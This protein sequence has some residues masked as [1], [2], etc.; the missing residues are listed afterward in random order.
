[1]LTFGFTQDMYTGLLDESLYLFDQST[2]MSV[3]LDFSLFVLFH[4]TFRICF[5]QNFIGGIVLL[6]VLVIRLMFMYQ[7]GHVM[8]NFSFILLYGGPCRIS[9][10]TFIFKKPIISLI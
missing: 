10:Y 6:P 9:L 7:R 5:P 3:N 2:N 8:L 1:M 4:L